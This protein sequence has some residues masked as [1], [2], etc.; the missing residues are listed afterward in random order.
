MVPIPRNISHSL[1]NHLCLQTLV[2]HS[3]LSLMIIV[4]IS[5]RWLPASHTLPDLCCSP[6]YPFPDAIHG[7]R[8][9]CRHLVPSVSAVDQALVDGRASATVPSDCGFLVI[10]LETYWITT[11]RG[12]GPFYGK[13]V[14]RSPGQHSNR[15]NE[16]IRFT[17]EQHHVPG[18]FI[19]V[20]KAEWRLVELHPGDVNTA[21]VLNETRFLSGTILFMVL[22]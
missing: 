5:L 12:F 19:L 7:S 10:P 13:D 3:F 16:I 4:T 2:S 18:V 20:R 6:R 21:C 15:G 22:E 17:R 8:A 11:L 9:F 14:L 1:P